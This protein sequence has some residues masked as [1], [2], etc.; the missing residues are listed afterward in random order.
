MEIQQ[1]KI[2]GFS[3]LLL[4]LALCASGLWLLLGPTQYQATVKI[5]VVPDPISDIGRSGPTGDSF[6]YEHHFFLTTFK[7]IRSEAVLTNVINA[8]NLND[9]WSKKRRWGGRLETR[10]TVKMLKRRVNL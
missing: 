7:T 1:T 8:L 10:Q 4:G 6:E 5:R 9:R 2:L 3:L